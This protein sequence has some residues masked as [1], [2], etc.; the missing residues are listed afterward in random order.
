MG[1]WVWVLLGA[2]LRYGS[3]MLSF[4]DERRYPVPTLGTLSSFSARPNVASPRVLSC[5][6][7]TDQHSL[8]RSRPGSLRMNPYPPSLSRSIHK[9]V[10]VLNLM[11]I[12][13]NH[14]PQA[15]TE[16]PSGSQPL[17]PAVTINTNESAF[18]SPSSPWNPSA[19]FSSPPPAAAAAGATTTPRSRHRHTS[20]HYHPPTDSPFLSSPPSHRP[21]GPPALNA[22]FNLLLP[23]PSS[24]QTPATPSP[25][26]TPTGEVPAGHAASTTHGS[27]FLPGSAAALP[28]GRLAA[29]NS[30]ASG[31]TVDQLLSALVRSGIIGS[32]TTLPSTA[33][34]I[35]VADQSSALA[36]PPAAAAGTAA[37]ADAAGG[38]S[39][40]SLLPPPS[41]S[42]WV[43]RCTSPVRLSP[44][45]DS[46]VL[47]AQLP[48]AAIQLPPASS[49]RPTDAR[50]SAGAGGD[51]RTATDATAAAA[52]P[53]ATAGNLG[54]PAAAEAAG[55][56]ELDYFRLSL[57]HDDS[58]D[59]E[60][61][62]WNTLTPNNAGVQQPPLE[63]AGGP[64]SATGEA[65]WP[66]SP[67]ASGDAASGA[68]P[69][70]GEGDEGA[71]QD[72]REEDEE[73]GSPFVWAAWPLSPAPPPPPPLH[74]DN[75]HEEAAGG[76]AGGD[77]GSGADVPVVL[78]RLESPLHSK[79]QPSQLHRGST[80]DGARQQD[81]QQQ[82][83]QQSA[84][85]GTGG[86]AGIAT[87]P[88]PP[89]PARVHSSSS[90][91]PL[92][93][94]GSGWASHSH[95]HQPPQLQHPSG[96]GPQ[97]LY[98]HHQEPQVELS[99][100]YSSPWSSHAA[101]AS[102]SL[103]HDP[104]GS[105]C[106]P[107]IQPQPSSTPVRPRP[108]PHPHAPPE[109]PRC[110]TPPASP[111]PLLPPALASQAGLAYSPLLNSPYTGSM[112]LSPMRHGGALPSSTCSTRGGGGISSGG[113]ASGDGTSSGGGG[114]GG[115]MDFELSPFSAPPLMPT[116]ST[117]AA[118][119][120]P[121]S[122]G[123][124]DD[125]A[126]VAAADAA[127]CSMLLDAD[128]VVDG[129][130]LPPLPVPPPA[131]RLRSESRAADN[132][133]AGLA[134]AFQS[135]AEVPYDE[136]ELAMAYSAREE[137]LP[138]PPPPP[139]PAA[140]A[141]L[142]PPPLPLPPRAPSRASFLGQSPPPPP[143]PPRAPS[144]IGGLFSP[145]SAA[146]SPYGFSYGGRRYGGVPRAMSESPGAMGG[147][148]FWALGQLE[149][150][151][152]QKQQEAVLARLPSRQLSRMQSQEL[153][154]PPQ[155]PSGVP[156]VGSA[157]SFM[158]GGQA[159]AQ[160]QQQQQQQ[161]QQQ[162]DQQGQRDGSTAD[163]SNQL[164]TAVRRP[165]GPAL[166]PPPPQG[167]VSQR[168]VSGAA[169]GGN[170]TAPSSPYAPVGT[171]YPLTTV[172][173]TPS[174]TSVTSNSSGASNSLH[175]R[176]GYYSPQPTAARQQHQQQQQPPRPRGTPGRTPPRPPIPSRSS[177][178]G[179]RA[180]GPQRALPPSPP[181]VAPQGYSSTAQQGGSPGTGGR[182]GA[183]SGCV[184]A[185][186]S[187]AGGGSWG[188]VSPSSTSTGGAS[189]G[190][191]GGGSG[192]YHRRS[193]SGGGGGGGCRNTGGGSSSRG[194]GGGADRRSS[195][196]DSNSGGGSSGKEE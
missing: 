73:H 101:W 18:A 42:T 72:A 51:A 165:P 90:L 15:S 96:S 138:P 69:D 56:S 142:A 46:A 134:E 126:A 120:Q 23:T 50:A 99:H 182:V 109:P 145:A 158:S 44:A 25:S 21:A 82:Q 74:G 124:S 155:R 39:S 177:V 97:A 147:V 133:L 54:S 144:S 65:A 163:C 164:P 38:S 184:P 179:G 136:H 157:M 92:A 6:L 31:S 103:Y 41:A 125:A 118:A 2:S 70:M 77:A 55:P 16:E 36:I 196:S 62:L 9:V 170:N 27:P 186:A 153:P 58:C 28:S 121:P 95:H 34:S 148:P 45:G 112:R 87:G 1:W 88:P 11:A 19:S 12:V 13:V 132:Y 111:D 143:L 115:D 22:V 166:S 76:D 150:A 47:L 20:P 7:S 32:A 17:S 113:G 160:W 106:G 30:S 161:W 156:R 107:A 83:Q 35:T 75:V 59:Q 154:P 94:T 33:T 171:T 127:V 78:E 194:G 71:V 174:N 176:P 117:I 195:S 108:Q 193:S 146:G 181:A 63:A 5:L 192:G 152:R 81:Q 149:L 89:P 183:G 141:P 119:S 131:P 60:P 91:T 169:A 100:E 84:A 79:G 175:G 162:Q 185:G 14:I 37:G 98:Q 129:M 159:S 26:S 167:A 168:Q 105:V 172:T 130:V 3:G 102:S 64:P 137:A 80:V 67:A 8:R 52:A 139:L 178:A 114:G 53:T 135:A 24:G 104:S 29:D 128:S 68:V 173:N 187:V 48:A 188:S 86:H 85:G 40:S 116:P 110:T 151:R 93:P 190:G 122:Y 123:S 10:H 43:L 191:G 49:S 57:P 66:P 61:M 189:S 140:A 4:R 180:G